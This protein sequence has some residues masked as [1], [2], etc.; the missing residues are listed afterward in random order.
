VELS[1][2]CAVA[3]ASGSGTDRPSAALQRIR[4]LPEVLLPCQQATIDPFRTFGAIT[5]KVPNRAIL[6]A[7]VKIPRP[8]VPGHV[9]KACTNLRRVVDSYSG[10]PAS[11]IPA[12]SRRPVSAGSGS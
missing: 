7:S 6:R 12:T 2:G 11:R 10:M 9:D 5:R 1:L 4:Q 3:I 8:A